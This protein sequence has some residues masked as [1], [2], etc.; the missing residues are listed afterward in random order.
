MDPLQR[1]YSRRSLLPAEQQ[2]IDV[3]GLTLDEYWEFCRLAD[4][5]AKERGKEYA[6]IPEIVA[7]GEPLTTYQIVSLVLGVVS[8][9]ASVLLQPDSP[10]FEQQA[11][12][13][14]KTE[15]IRGQTKFAELFSF[16]SVQDLAAL[17]SIIPLIFAKREQLPGS[18]EFVGGVRA[19]GLL[20]WSQ[21]LSLGSHQELKMLTTLGLSALGATPDAQGLAIGDQLLRNYQEARYKA[22]FLDNTASGG[23]V[24]QADAISFAGQLPD[25]QHEDV[26]LAYDKLKSEFRPLLSGTRTP[27]SQRTFG[28]HSPISNGSPYFFPYDIVQIFG[29][30]ESLMEKRDKINGLNLN[31]NLR[32]YCGRQAMERLNNVVVNNTRQIDVGDTLIFRNSFAREQPDAFPPHGLDDVNTAIDSRMSDTD[33]LINIGDLF[34]FGSSIIQCTKRPEKPYENI[35]L[36]DRQYEF[37]CKEQGFGYFQ[38]ADADPLQVANEPYGQHLQR[39]DIATV[40]SNRICDQTEIGI[41]SVVY[42]RIDNFANVNSEPPVGI[43]QQY[44]TDRQVFSLGRVSTYQTRYSFFKIEFREIGT[45]N[46]TA[47]TDISAGQIFAVRGNNP[48]PQYN[49]IRVNHDPGQYEFRLVPVTGSTA[50]GLYV[51]IDEQ[52]ND[53][54]LLNGNANLNLAPI[55]AQGGKVRVSCTGA[56]VKITNLDASNDEFFFKRAEQGIEQ[57]GQ[58]KGLDKFT[59]GELPEDAKWELAEGPFVN[60]NIATNQLIYGVYVNV[61][62]PTADGAVFARWNGEPVLLG[63]EYQ[64]RESDLVEI[65][66]AVQK[67]EV[68]ETASLV[69]SGEPIAGHHYVETY[70]NGSLKGAVFGTDNGGDVTAFTQ[71]PNLD[72]DFSK[73][74]RVVP[75][76]ARVEVPDDATISSQTAFNRYKQPDLNYYGV[77]V[78]RFDGIKTAIWDGQRV[79]L[80]EAGSEVYIN[81]VAYIQGVHS[82]YDANID[83]DVFQIVKK[84]QIPAGTVRYFQPIQKVEAV[85]A[86]QALKLYKISRYEFRQEEVSFV[87]GGSPA[88][89]NHQ[90]YSG[91]GSGFK[92]NASSFAEGQWQWVIA[93][94]GLNYKAGEKLNF[95]F[96]DGTLVEVQVTQV[97]SIFIDGQD[98]PPLNLKDAIADYPKFDLETTSHQDGPEHEVVFVNEMVR[99]E[100][101]KP[102]YGAA[103]Y[104]DLSLLGLR[105]LAG[106][107]WS[108]MGQLSAYIKEGIKVER[109]IDNSG[110]STASLTASTNNFAEIAF[111]LLVSDRLGAGKRIPR[112]TIDRDA[113]TIAAKFCRANGFRFDGIVGDRVGLRE[114]IHANAAFNLLDFS[115][116]GGKFS[117]TPSVPYDPSTFVIEPAQDITQKVK[118][119]FTD[120]NMKDMQVSFLPTQER[121]LFKATVAYRQEEENGFSSQKVT[122]MRFKDADGGSDSDPEEFIDLTTFCT[123]SKHAKQIA[124]YKLL[125][126][127]HSEHNIQFK[128]T[129]SSALSIAPGDYIKVISNASHTSRFNNG[130]IDQFG[131][132]TSTT[133]LANGTYTVFYWRP[134]ETQVQ[135]G[136]LQVVGGKT[137]NETFFSSIFTIKMQNQQKRIYRVTSLTIDD[138]G[139]VDI[140]GSYQKVDQAGRLAIL[141]PDNLLFD[142]TD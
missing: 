28:C 68:L 57:K 125:L 96:N 14:I 15:D 131:G 6:S 29:D 13:A 84:V 140:G 132:V 77:W 95:E 34:A 42:K 124:E 134:G 120:G 80:S 26:F 128:T 97:D 94:P 123:S 119:L 86:V 56:P 91:S 142:V 130:S 4:C 136:Q 62:N 16:D 48:Q 51:D 9:A 138:D 39:L 116:V 108:S 129:P 46:D 110:N 63:S 25:L 78:R 19:K 21:L 139:F 55:S 106:R 82:E 8:T 141:N 126:R 109:L 35:D 87:P 72:D 64:Y 12:S 117:L 98:R 74:Y 127:K 1:S 73:R 122:Q 58:V 112:D 20:L 24:N 75:G 49:T 113:M 67:F 33:T 17:G 71:D 81:N 5:K 111:N 115:I 101:D 40:T 118:A 23:R 53:V 85:Q 43:L 7:T 3:L 133:A 92:V 107:D 47:F 76:S 50:A 105:V 37:I 79:P 114:F 30:D 69:Y 135:E 22:Y 137:T 102:N 88:E 11:P 93:N 38:S 32:P 83:C 18:N 31:L 99:P 10:S 44:E 104:N 70:A 66:P 59:V 41:K 121:Q 52:S 2:I 89:Y 36:E 100:E 60:R 45:H 27:S 90:S 54:Y 65:I 61:D 103:Q